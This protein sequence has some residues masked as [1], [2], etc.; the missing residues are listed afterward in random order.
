[1]R[2]VSCDSYGEPTAA[3]ALRLS[4]KYHDEKKGQP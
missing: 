3:I 1:M 4:S 2:T